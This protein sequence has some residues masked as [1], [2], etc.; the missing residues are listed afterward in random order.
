MRYRVC[1]HQRLG[2]SDVGNVCVA[3]HESRLG[4]LLVSLLLPAILPGRPAGRNSPPALSGSSSTRVAGHARTSVCHSSFYENCNLYVCS[5][6][7]RRPNLLSCQIKLETYF[8]LKP[9]APAHIFEKISR[10]L[11]LYSFN[12]HFS[13]FLVSKIR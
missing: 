1:A 3:G 9:A 5:E 11:L 7:S 6:T 13:T 10:H 8:L 12:L 4:L 2:P